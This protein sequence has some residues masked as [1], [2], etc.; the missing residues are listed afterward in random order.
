LPDTDFS[1][2]DATLTKILP[3]ARTEMLAPANHFSALLPCKP[4]GAKLLADD[5]DDPVC[6][7]P[8]GTDRRALHR[9]MVQSIARHFGLTK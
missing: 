2:V 7:D 6:T 9:Q 1:A 4:A 3:T 5:N 8:P